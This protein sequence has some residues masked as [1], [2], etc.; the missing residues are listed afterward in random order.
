MKEDRLITGNLEMD[1]SSAE[2]RPT[3]GDTYSAE[4]KYGMIK[5]GT[6][7][8]LLHYWTLVASHGMSFSIH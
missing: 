8:L 4:H 7:L 1:G 6:T 2:V 3:Q 5:T